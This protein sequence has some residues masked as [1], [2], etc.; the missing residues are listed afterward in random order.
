MSTPTDTRTVTAIAAATRGRSIPT[1]GLPLHTP[2]QPGD[3]A[4]AVE[5]GR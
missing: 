2:M 1:T 4:S 5:R 3:A